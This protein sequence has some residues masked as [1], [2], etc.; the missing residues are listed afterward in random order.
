MIFSTI[1]FKNY[2]IALLFGVLSVILITITSTELVIR[3]LVEPNHNFFIHLNLIKTTE[4]SCIALG[5]SHTALGFTGNNECINLAYPGESFSDTYKKIKYLKKPENLRKIILQADPLIF[6]KNRLDAKSGIIIHYLSSNE[7]SFLKV[8]DPLHTKN[9]IR[10]WR[11]LLFKRKFTPIFDVHETGWM[12]YN[13]RWTSLTFKE[14][15]LK[16][17]KEALEQTPIRN[18]SETETATLFKNLINSYNEK[19]IEICLITY[20]MSIEFIQYAEENPVFNEVLLYFK[21]LAAKD[22]VEYINM[23]K[24]KGN[25]AEYFAN[26]DHLNIKGAE[27][28]TMDILQQCR[29]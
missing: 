17:K 25:N 9:L 26:A 13:E 3:F 2:L 8:L 16:A 4:S 5:D 21:N 19:G 14:R 11:T 24:W 22:K 27:A 20:P 23:L 28:L 1:S 29:Y 7:H 12:A 10:Y 6:S 18:F 15:N